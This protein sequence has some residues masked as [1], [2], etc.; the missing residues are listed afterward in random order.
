MKFTKVQ[1][2]RLFQLNQ[3]WDRE[4]KDWIEVFL[5]WRFSVIPAIL[6]RVLFCTIFAFI[7]SLIYHFLPKE[8]FTFS[9]TIESGLI[10]AIFLALLLVFRTNTAYDKFWEGR[11]LWGNLINHIRNLARSIWIAVEEKNL[12]DRNEKIIHIRLLIAFIYATKI[13]LRDEKVNEELINLMPKKWYEKLKTMNHPPLEIAFWIGDYLQHKFDCKC[14]NP[15]QL[16]ACL[17]LLDNMVDALGGCERIKKTPIPLAYSIHLKHLL[18][19]Y[20]LTFSFQIVDNLG[21]LTAVI[22][23]IV[24]FTVFGIEAIGIEIE[25][26]FGYD[27]NDLPLDDMCH[28]MFR[29]VEDLIS[30]AP[31]VRHWKEINFKEE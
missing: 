20:C 23:A 11:K 31:S 18:F 30:L 13:Y 5:Q 26:P 28:T 19:L 29:N 10:P 6:P 2:A 12:Q 3:Q 21:F 24:S 27:A 9:L 22:V 25:N 17:K 15:Y 8:T 1:Q 16:T 4:K 7:L 14:I